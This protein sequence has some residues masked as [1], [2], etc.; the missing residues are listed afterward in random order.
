MPLDPSEE[1][2]DYCNSKV[3]GDRVQGYDCGDKVAEW[4]CDHLE[5]PGLRLLRQCDFTENISG[6]NSK[7]GKYVVCRF[8]P[9]NNL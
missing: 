4:L 1:S 6:R 5:K 8:N 7:L 2:D 3:C 9:R